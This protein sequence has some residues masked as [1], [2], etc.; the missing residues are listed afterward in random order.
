M[1]AGLGRGQPDRDVTADRGGLHEEQ[2]G[3]TTSYTYDADGN[4][5]IRKDGQGSTLYLPGGNELTLGADGKK[6]GTRYYEIDGEPVA[7][8]TGGEVQFLFADHHGTATTA[9]DATTQDITHRA[10]APFGEDRA[11]VS[12]GAGAAAAGA[13]TAAARGWPGDRGF[14]NGTKDSTGL[15][16]LGA[17]AYD[18]KLGRFLSVDPMVDRGESQRMNAYAYANNNPVAFS[19]PDG[20]FFGKIKNWVKKTTKKA[21]KTVTNA[22][23]KVVKKYAKKKVQSFSKKVKKTSNYIK[24]KSSRGWSKAKS[25]GE[26]IGGGMKKGWNAATSTGMADVLGKVSTVTGVL[27]GVAAV[28][29]VGAPVAGMLGAISLGTGVASAGIYASREG[30]G[31]QNFKNAAVG[32]GLGVAGGGFGKLAG[33]GAQSLGVRGARFVGDGI[34]AALPTGAKGSLTGVGKYMAL[35]YDAMPAA[36]GASTTDWGNWSL[37]NR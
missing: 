24:Q 33:R 11:A 31:S 14:V 22:A 6:A 10:L 17:R 2:G 36:V 34:K 25:A 8:R 7:A 26:V 4:R 5:L 35:K 20:L 9:V 1:R 32:V 28:T 16:Q 12:A 30:F 18:P 19:D 27:A 13:L 23:K 15:T 29:G 3:A 21:V 37:G